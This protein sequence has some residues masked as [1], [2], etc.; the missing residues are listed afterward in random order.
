MILSGKRILQEIK[1]GAIDISPFDETKLNPNSYN[2]R[3]ADEL[4]IY[5]NGM[6][7][8]KKDIPYTRVKIP[9]S[10]YLLIP[11]KLYLGRT[12]ERTKTHGFVP[13]I[14][15]RSSVG[16]FGVFV[17][18]TAGF[19][20]NG[21]EGYWTF[22]ISCVQPAVIYPN[23]EFAQIYFHTLSEVDEDG[24]GHEVEPIKYSDGKY[25]DNH[26][27]QTSMLWKELQG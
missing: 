8:M 11:G 9:E 19:G 14:E 10:G 26:D 15:G 24:Y 5:D 27:I 12:V 22:E 4:L 2:V 23:I 13:M 25:Q 21:F 6:L 3:L 17:H 20:D 16:R 7:D 18:S 1:R